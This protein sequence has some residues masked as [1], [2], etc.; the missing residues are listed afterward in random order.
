MKHR[1]CEYG[2]CRELADRHLDFF[3]DGKVRHVCPEHAGKLLRTIFW[4]DTKIEEATVLSR[5]HQWQLEDA[6]LEAEAEA[7]KYLEE[8]N[9]ALKE[10]ERI[11]W[12]CRLRELPGLYEELARKQLA[13]GVAN[14]DGITQ[15]ELLPVVGEIP[16]EDVR[17][18]PIDD[19]AE[20]VDGWAKDRKTPNEEP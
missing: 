5:F 3:A 1:A 20:T 11:G 10:L 12:P 2:N 15:L 16:I 6:C 13:V 14:A 18:G 19:F 8:Y 7:E 9:A 17:E 4:D